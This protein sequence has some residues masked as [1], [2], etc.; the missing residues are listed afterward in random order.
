MAATVREEGLPLVSNSAIQT[1]TAIGEGG[2]T[3]PSDLDLMNRLT[4]A[5]D[6]QAFIMLMTRYQDRLYATAWRLSRNHELSED[7]VQETFI[8]LWK[9]SKQWNPD[10]GKLSTWLYTI[11][12]NEIKCFYRSN[13]LVLKNG[14]QETYP[15]QEPNA[16]QI[17]QNSSEERAV[18][19]AIVSLPDKQKQA[20]ILF[21]YEDLPQKDIAR[22]MGLSSKAVERLISRARENLKNKLAH[23]QEG[24]T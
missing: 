24:R 21:T 18:R 19:D 7:S 13:R 10:K 16:I 8:T 20:L 23:L 15:D 5:Q 1:K 22:I 12:L 6:R 11:L 17:L 14:Y 4:N 3:A 9:K 2:D